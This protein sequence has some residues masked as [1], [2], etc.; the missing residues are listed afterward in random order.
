MRMYH[1]LLMVLIAIPAVQAQAFVL[2]GNVVHDGVY[3][4]GDVQNDGMGKI[5]QQHKDNRNKLNIFRGEQ[6]LQQEKQW[7]RN[8]VREIKGK[9][10]L[11]YEPLFDDQHAKRY[12]WFVDKRDWLIRDD[13]MEEKI[14]DADDANYLQRV[15]DEQK[16]MFRAREI[17]KARFGE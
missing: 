9:K 8:W 6:E 2:N 12:A 16:G 1:L 17:A 3:I 15:E 14:I 4:L 7:K 5:L 10:Y 13:A 11:G